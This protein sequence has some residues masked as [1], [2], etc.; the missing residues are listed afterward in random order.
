MDE[1][2]QEVRL[3]RV[4]SIRPAAIDILRFELEPADR[5]PFAP[6]TAGAHIDVTTPAGPVRQYS[7]CGNPSDARRYAIA[8]KREA[9]GRG[10]SI[11]MHGAL[12]EGEPLAFSGPRNLFKLAPAGESLLIAGG[13]G[14]TPIYAMAQALAAAGRPWELHYCARS[15]EHAAFRSELEVLAQGRMSTYFSEAPLLDAGALLREVRPETHVYCCG[16]APLMQAVKQAAAHWPAERVHFEYFAAPAIAWPPNQPFEV[17]LARSGA[18]LQVPRDRSILQVLRADGVDVHS[19]CEEGVCGTCETRVLAGEPEH[20][21]MLLTDAE[22][23]AGR[24]M[25][26]CV[27]R[28]RSPRLVLDL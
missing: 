12:E 16:P 17:E 4:A 28:S 19:A 1:A 7:L 26:V 21:D 22:K 5:R 27:S 8:V 9:E 18:V 2:G 25:M 23:A 11:S 13:I 3:A 14:I 10:G 20:R 6:F 24:T 15:A